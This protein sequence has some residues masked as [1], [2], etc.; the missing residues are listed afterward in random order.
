M[1][2]THLGPVGLV[3]NF[4]WGEILDFVVGFTTLDI[5]QDDGVRF[6]H[7]PW[8]PPHPEPKPAVTAVAK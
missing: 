7:W 4:R 2:Y 6:G 3:T 8:L 5:A 1:H